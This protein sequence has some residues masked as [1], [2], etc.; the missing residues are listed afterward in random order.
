MVCSLHSNK[1][2]FLPLTFMKKEENVKFDNNLYSKCTKHC[3]SKC[4]DI[5]FYVFPVI[6]HINKNKMDDDDDA[7]LKD[8]ELFGNKEN[9]RFELKEKIK[10]KVVTRSNLA[11]SLNKDSQS[12]Q[13]EKIR[14]DL[15]E[16]KEGIVLLKKSPIIQGSI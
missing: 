7:D 16:I 13:T 5:L 12:T 14:A 8:D 9:Q 2:V 1:L 3:I 6:L 4:D 11:S 10:I 15:R